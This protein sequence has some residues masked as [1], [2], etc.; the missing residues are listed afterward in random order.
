MRAPQLSSS[1][2]DEV[3]PAQRKPLQLAAKDHQQRH[4][5]ARSPVSHTHQH[6]QCGHQIEARPG[7]HRLGHAQRHRHQVAD[8]KGPEPEADRHRQLF[9][10]QLRDRLVLEEAGAQVE[11]RELAQHLEETLVR[12]LVKA[13]Q[14]LDLLQPLRVHALGTPVNRAAFR[15][16]ACSGTRLRQVLLHRPAGHELDHDESQQQHPEQRRDHQ[17]QALEDVGPHIRVSPTRCRSPSPRRW[18]R[19]A[20]HP[21]GRGA[22]RC[23]PCGAC[24]K[25][26]AAPGSGCA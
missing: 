20:W 3:R 19:E 6:Q 11:A 24:W 23:R 1:Q 14:G 5:R 17:Q 10:D 13:V 26:I 4:A 8:Q 18:H 9:D 16:R 21:D 7:P 22:R 25:T 15:A 2:F 12:G